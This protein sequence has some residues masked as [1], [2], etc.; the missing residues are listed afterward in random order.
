MT[1]RG[2]RTR[3]RARAR[4]KL[5]ADRTDFLVSDQ[6][7]ASWIAGRRSPEFVEPRREQ[8]THEFA[9]LSTGRG[10][11]ISA[12]LPSAQPRG[13]NPSDVSTLRQY[14]MHVL[15]VIKWQRVYRPRA[16]A[17]ALPRKLS[18][19]THPPPSPSP[20]RRRRR[21]RRQPP[22][23]PQRRHFRAASRLVMYFSLTPRNPFRGAHSTLEYSSPLVTLPSGKFSTPS[24]PRGAQ[25]VLITVD[26]SSNDG[27]LRGGSLLS[28]CESTP[29]SSPD[30]I[31]SRYSY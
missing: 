31:N 25:Q 23:G 4:R 7:R 30:E 17:A 19:L 1:N 8:S 21:R 14:L 28:R 5:P 29:S 26:A 11:K 2:L 12:H 27:R 3:A 24:P 18:R 22:V 15:S 20:R 9:N 10:G 13:F 6:S 16:T